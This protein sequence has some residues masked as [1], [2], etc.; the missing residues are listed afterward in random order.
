MQQVA[1]KTGVAVQ[2]VYLNFRTKAGL[3]S[4]VGD[5]VI[6]GERPSAAWRDEPWARELL[7]ETDPRRVVERFVEAAVAITR[8]LVPFVRA[9]GADLPN[10]PVSAASRDRGRD[11]FFGAAL[12][13]LASLNALRPGLSVTHALDIVR[14]VNTLEAYV[15]LTGRRGWSDADWSAWLTELLSQQL[16]G[17]EPSVFRADQPGSK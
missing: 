7:G 10:D 15:D 13:R 6:L 2:T 11:D 17:D 16:L 14:A 5:T 4:E 12:S 1:D 8:R 3:L 9:V